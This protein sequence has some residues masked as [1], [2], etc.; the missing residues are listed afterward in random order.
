M[1]E[2]A[3]L[4][5]AAEAALVAQTI[6]D[7]VMASY[8][9]RAARR[10]NSTRPT[11][12]GVPC[13]LR[14]YLLRTEGDGWQPGKRN[15]MRFEMGNTIEKQTAQR[16]RDAGLEVL[17]TSHAVDDDRLQMTGYIDLWLRLDDGRLVPLEVKSCAPH[18]FEN[19]ETLGDML[20][21][22]YWWVRKYPAQI[23]AY[24]F[25]DPD[26]RQTPFGVIVLRALDGRW[27]LVPVPL[28]LDYA[29]ELMQRAERVAAAME[30]GKEPA[31]IEYDEDVCGHCA[32]VDRCH[33]D[34]ENGDA[35]NLVE[36]PEAEALADIMARS[37]LARDNYQRAHAKLKAMAE[38]T[39]FTGTLVCGAVAITR[40]TIHKKAVPERPAE[41]AKPATTAEQIRLNVID[42][43][44]D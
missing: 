28:D 43:D 10:H 44:T 3:T 32:F 18:V 29:E 42:K 6:T 17:E 14:L 19:V 27:K 11:E 23:T 30:A 9:P 16:M 33:A 35:L 8:K 22:R 38:A 24:L 39:T 15:L 31:P 25:I 13:D 12:V 26:A 41:P 36:D 7:K 2:R 1:T 4:D 34:R 5:P 20:T 40:K 21:S 37:K